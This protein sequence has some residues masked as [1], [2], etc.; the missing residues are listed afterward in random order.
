MRVSFLGGTAP[1]VTAAIV[2]LFLAGC[3][4]PPPPP[5]KARP[6]PTKEAAYT[7]AIDQLASINR[8][9]EALLKG[10]RADDAAAAITKGLPLQARLLAAPRPTLAAM[11]AVSDLDDLYARALLEGGHDVWARS[12]YEKNIAR[13]KLWNPQTDETARRLRQEQAG[14]A[15]CDRHMSR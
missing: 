2:M 8:Q 14:V 1:A 9:A 12:F 13:W 10:G 7:D 15:E 5:E 4:A 6:D 3:A 11:E